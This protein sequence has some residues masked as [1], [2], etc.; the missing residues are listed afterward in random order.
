MS[1]RGR[2]SWL[3]P[4]LLFTFA[5]VSCLRDGPS[6][7]IRRPAPRDVHLE[8]TPQLHVLITGGDAIEIPRVRRA[9]DRVLAT[10]VGMRARALIDTVA[11]EG[12]P[13][14]IELNA[15]RDNHTVY[16]IPG[17]ELSETISFDPAAFPLVETQDGPRAA[18]PETVL[19]HELGH[20]VFK[21]A[22]EEA[23]IREVENPVR[24]ELGL[25]LR[26]RF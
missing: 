19:A 16:R 23:V 2:R 21:L 20:A 6:A 3:L 7:P 8:L 11:L 14:H 15:Q 13:L 17:R 10:R 1:R 12:H 22:S 18:P 26:V 9:L 5:S 4:A 24:A 25:P